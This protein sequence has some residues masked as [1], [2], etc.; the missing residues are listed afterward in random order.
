MI[1]RTARALIAQPSL[2][3]IWNGVKKIPNKTIV[4]LFGL[5]KT[6][7]IH[8][9]GVNDHGMRYCGTGNSMRVVSTAG[10]ASVAEVEQVAES[11]SELLS[12]KCSVDAL[13]RDRA[14][15]GNTRK[16]GDAAEWKEPKSFHC[17][18]L[19]DAAGNVQA[20][21]IVFVNSDAATLR[22]ARAGDADPVQI[23]FDRWNRL[24]MGSHGMR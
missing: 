11:R 14:N 1:G 4:V 19:S 10:L 12:L 7:L 18:Y 5:Y 17:S 23:D 6:N 9:S 15:R 16:R 13:I 2:H 20:S 24:G 22:E 8:Q 21:E 3:G